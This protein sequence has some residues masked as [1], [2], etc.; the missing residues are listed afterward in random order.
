MIFSTN[1]LPLSFDD[2][3]AFYRRWVILNFPNKFDETKGKGLFEKITT[4]EEL[5]G[6]FNRAVIGLKRLLD[7]GR[8][9]GQKTTEQVRE[10][11][12]RLSDSVQAFTMDCIEQSADGWIEKKELYRVY[13][14]YCK[15]KNIPIS[16]EKRFF[17]RIGF[18]VRVEECKLT[19]SERKRVNAFKGIVFKI[20][21]NSVYLEENIEDTMSTMSTIS[22]ISIVGS[23]LNSSR[24]KVDGWCERNR[25]NTGHSGQPDQK[26]PN[27]L[28]ELVKEKSVVFQ[29][30]KSQNIN[31]SNIVEFSMWFCKETGNSLPDE[32][33]RITE[34]MFAIT[35]EQTKKEPHISFLCKESRCRDCGGH[36][37]DCECHKAK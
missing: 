29:S 32:I 35:P 11:Y 14:A 26:P 17:S 6:M 5:S 16:S 7:N 23:I 3:D 25:A 13:G 18:S 9:S 24:D 27:T 33:K 21:I 2:T 4:Q 36:G 22:P 31:S 20:D 28:T 10:Q 8:F 12:I 37:C 30:M 15:S 19:N 34:K 1:K